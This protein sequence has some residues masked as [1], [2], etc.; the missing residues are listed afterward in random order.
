[1][2]EPTLVT[3]IVCSIFATFAFALAR[4]ERMPDGLKW[5]LGIIGALLVFY[6]FLTAG[7]WVINRGVAYL[8]AIRQGWM[9]PELKLA[10]LIGGLNSE[11]LR[12]YERVSPSLQTIVYL[13]RGDQQNMHRLRT[14]MGEIDYIWIAKYLDDC[15]P[16]YPYLVPQHGKPGNLER[17]WIM[18]FTNEMVDKEMADRA[19]GNQPAKWRVPMSDV[20][21]KFGLD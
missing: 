6:A 21:K 16:V 1:M 15:E 14:P 2:R 5:A 11:Q 12:V 8:G 18:W 9:S 17:D 10:G 13:G 3:P 20:W 19:V 7:D 4:I